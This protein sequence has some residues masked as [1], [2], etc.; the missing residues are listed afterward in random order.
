LVHILSFPSLN[1]RLH[2]QPSLKTPL[3]P[4]AFRR[5]LLSFSLA[6]L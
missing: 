3:V 1:W 5:Q 4:I 2:S 6:A